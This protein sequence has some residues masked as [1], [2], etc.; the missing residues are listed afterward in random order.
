M[1][2]AS[3]PEASFD[4]SYPRKDRESRP[5]CPYSPSQKWAAQHKCIQLDSEQAVYS[6]LQGTPRGPGIGP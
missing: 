4:P 2:P 5:A 6:M 1:Q 3:S